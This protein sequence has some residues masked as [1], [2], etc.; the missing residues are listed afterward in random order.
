MADI[1]I[2]GDII[3]NDY[4]EIYNWFGYDCT[5]PRRVASAIAETPEDEAIDV[6]IN[7]P[8]GY[9]AAGQEIYTRLRSDGRV[10]CHV[11]GQACSAASIIAMG[12]K[13]CD[14]SPVGL[15]MV[16]C[17]ATCAEGNHR[18]FEGMARTLKTIDRALAEAYA[19][20]SGMSLEDA[21]KM[22]EKETW[23][24]ANQC[25][26]LGLCDA[27]MPDSEGAG[28]LD[29]VAAA[30]SPRVTPTMVAEFKAAREREKKEIDDLI[31]DLDTY[32][33]RIGG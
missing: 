9:V 11:I 14:I 1:Q 30:G 27:I 13:Y 25:V 18:D 28:L 33:S 24:T 17:A 29:A 7:S 6:Y 21:I 19:E 12:G 2:L 10:R 26:E 32:G 3:P 5:S 22:M 20:K 15:L 23:L 31:G 8:G 16:H 4:E